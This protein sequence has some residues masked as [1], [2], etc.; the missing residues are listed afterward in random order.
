ML[1]CTL[2]TENMK[3]NLHMEDVLVFDKTRK[4]KE[5]EEIAKALNGRS[6]YDIAKDHGF[7]WTEEERL[8]SLWW[9]TPKKWKDYKDGESAYDI[10][11]RNGFKGTEQEWIDSLTTKLNMKWEDVVSLI[12]AILSKDDKF[13]IDAKHIKWLQKQK[14]EIVWRQTHSVNWIPEWWAI[15]YALF[16]K[17][18][19]D[20]D[21]EWRKIE[22]WWSGIWNTFET[23]SKNLQSY[24]YTLT[25]GWWIL[26]SIEYTL[27]T[28]T[29]TKTLNYW[30]WLLT[31]IVL[32]WDIPSGIE[33]TK[34][35]N[36]TSWT[37]TSITYS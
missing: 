31:S 34:T 1:T 25:Y 17:S 30:W 18:E 3:A 10:A 9:Y 16:K 23:V 32:S 20:F 28:W 14:E 11:V 15:N 7:E 6:A 4:E 5:Q 35:L 26:T 37:L 2:K 24:P 12:N 19:K 33:T 29:I 27:P 8:E 21:T 13:K 36:Y 22:S